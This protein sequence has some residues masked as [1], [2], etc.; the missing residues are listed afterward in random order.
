VAVGIFSYSLY[1]IHAPL[2]QVIWQ[3]GINPLG[4]SKPL[5]LVLMLGVGGPLIV[6]CAYG[7]FRAVERPSMT[8]RQRRDRSREL[9]A[10]RTVAR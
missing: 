8:M 10:V 6:G 3:Y 4:L 7:F 9:A 5:D 2:E 1:L